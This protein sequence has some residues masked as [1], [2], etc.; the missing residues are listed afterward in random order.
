MRFWG[1]AVV[2]G[3]AEEDVVYDLEREGDWVPLEERGKEGRL[4]NN[5]ATDDHR[6]LLPV[7]SL[8]FRLGESGDVG[9]EGGERHLSMNLM[10]GMRDAIVVF[11][12][13]GEL[14]KGRWITELACGGGRGGK[15]PLSDPLL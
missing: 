13:A 15:A 4:G 5:E 7:E 6:R 14:G 1:G 12:L 11:V 10:T 2:D 8:P 3:G 9:A